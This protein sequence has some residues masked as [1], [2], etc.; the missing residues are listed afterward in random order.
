MLKHIEADTEKQRSHHRSPTLKT[1][2]RLLS[3]QV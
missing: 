1:L 2:S 3:L